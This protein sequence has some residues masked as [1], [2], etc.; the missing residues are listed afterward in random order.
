[1]TT[2]TF[3]H[4]FLQ[5][6]SDLWTRFFADADQLGA[7]YRGTSYLIGQAYLDLL[8]SVLGVSLQD[9]PVFHK[10]YYK[11]ILMREDEVAYRKGA[12]LADDRWAFTLPD[13]VVQFAS[14]DNR[15]YEPTVSFQLNNDYDLGTGV[16][17]F[18]QDPSDPLHDG[19]PTPGFARRIVDVATG[20]SFD[21]T[22]RPAANSWGTTYGV[23]KGDVIRRLEQS[24]FVTPQKRLSDHTIALVRDTVLYV[25]TDTPFPVPSPVAPNQRFVILRTPPDAAVS[26]EQMVFIAD[27]ATLAH[28]RLDQGSVRVYAKRQSD[29]QDVVEGVD[30]T[31]DY[32][33]GIVYRTSTWAAASPDKINYTWK[34]Q[35]YPVAPFP[36]TSTTGVIRATP[37]SGTAVTTR[38]YQI[39]LWAPD[40]L[41]DQMTLA[42]NYGSLVGI[43]EKSSESYRA[44]LRGIFQLY[45]LG[46]VVERIESALNVILGLPVV[47]DDGETLLAVDTSQA[48]FNRITTNRP[49]TQTT[50]TYDFPKSTPLR[51]DLVPG[52]VLHAFEPLTTSVTVTDYIQDPTWWHNVIIPP[53]LFSTSDGAVVPT[54]PRRTVSPVFIKHVIGAPDTPKIGDPG[55]KIGADEAGQTAAFPGQPIYRHRLAFFL[56]DQYL[57]FHTFYVRFDPGVFG[58]TNVARYARSFD[59][60]QKL[61]VTSK[62][63]HTLAFIQPVTAFLD[64][65]D[66]VED[67]YYQPPVNPGQNPD[68]PS[69]FPNQGAVDP[70]WPWSELGLFFNLTIG[71][72]G[73]EAD[74][75][76]FADG[77]PQ[78]GVNGWQLGDYF[79]YE[80]WTET[81]A[82]PNFLPVALANT[83]A[84][85]RRARLVQVYVG[86]TIGGKRVVENI[87]YLVDYANRTITR[88]SAWDST[89]NITVKYVQANIGNVVNAPAD[90]TVGDM[91]LLIGGIDPARARAAYDPTAVDWLGNLIPVTDAR[92][93]SMVEHPVTIKII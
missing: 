21:D 66:M 63:A 27:V 26:F 68:G 59:D 69:I 7:L 78:I 19:N 34:S 85:P 20:G 84:A 48:T 36:A 24:P 29:G 47:R 65:V 45:M 46:P 57:K 51:T 33:S 87:D 82:F 76:L 55:L 81:L 40:A 37:A 43:E 32:E 73:N 1:M 44:L 79:H 17:L 75:V 77:P 54:L 52:L 88:Q 64:Q 70:M 4:N 80:N 91:P 58:D 10:E 39:A 38:V 25:S 61:I 92:D 22:A 28:Q 9:A 74:K 5:G 8:E 14:L 23:R 3:P 6:L 2:P 56:M 62:P 86:A 60:L 90:Q 83:P 89:V 49:A 18:K 13:N 71:A 41:V 42:N 72:P 50:G 15:V 12:T 16:A 30:Y 11:L 93:L 31:V 67:G 35:V 53:E